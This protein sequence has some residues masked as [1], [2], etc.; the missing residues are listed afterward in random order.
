[1]SEHVLNFF[2][3]RWKMFARLILHECRLSERTTTITL[4]RTRTTTIVVK[5][6]TSLVLH[7]AQGL[8]EPEDGI[9][10]YDE[11]EEEEEEDPGQ[12]QED[13]AKEDEHAEHGVR[14]VKRRF[15]S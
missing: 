7:D 15:V 14:L 9:D 1:M 5:P 3:I 4:L 11:E 10:I 6:T 8:G 12:E 13:P 2:S